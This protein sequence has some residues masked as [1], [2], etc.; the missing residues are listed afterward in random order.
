MG[1]V[2]LQRV[3]IVG[4]D[5]TIC[6]CS[7]R[8]TH[9]LPC[10]CELAKLQISGNVIPLDSIH[11]FWRKLSL[12]NEFV[13]EESLSDYDFLEELEAMKAY[14][15]KHDIASQ[16]IFRANVREVVFPHTT[17]ILAPLEKVRT[18][19][20][21]KKK[22]EFDTPR[23]PSYW[24]YV[25]ASQE[26]A[27]QPSQR[28]ARQPSQSSQYSAKQPF[29]THFPTLIHPYIEEIIDVVADGNCGFRAIAALL[30]WTEESWPLVRTQLDKEIHLHQDLYANVFDD[31]VESVRSSLNISGLGAQG[32]DKWMCFTPRDPSYWEYIIDVVADG[33][34]GLRAIAALLGWTEESWPLVRTQLDK[35]I[36]LHQDLYANVFD[37]SVESV[38]NSLNISGLGAQGQ[39]K[40]MCL[41]DLGYVIATRYNIILVSLSRNLNMT[42]FPLNKTPPSKERLLAIGF[43]NE[44]HWIKLKS[45]CP[46][47]P[48]SRKWKHI[49]LSFSKSSCISLNED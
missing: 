13:D 11:V 24:E 48:I 39:D 28:S 10:A 36:R 15:K 4:T 22:K 34:C 1:R 37:D 7:I 29:Y 44:N 14:M 33:N 19:G 47:P 6:G 20:S 21:S 8:T 42:F 35:E 27:K 45:N 43:V 16:R 23:D 12:E 41:P 9:G 38:R 40:W 25:D 3:K 32:Q 17:S 2:E 30:G 26:S 18:K 49:D 31:S 5:K 46:L